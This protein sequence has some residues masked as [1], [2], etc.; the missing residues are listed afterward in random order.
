V[1]SWSN[2]R[3]LE[4]AKEEEDEGEEEEEEEKGVAWGSRGRHRIAP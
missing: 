2:R 3:E 1:N 4:I